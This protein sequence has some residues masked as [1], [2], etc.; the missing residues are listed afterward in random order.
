MCVTRLP[1]AWLADPK[2][3]PNIVVLSIVERSVKA[4]WVALDAVNLKAC[5]TNNRA[6]CLALEGDL[7]GNLR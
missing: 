4:L 3:F 6:C 1:R 7:A 5:A 2:D